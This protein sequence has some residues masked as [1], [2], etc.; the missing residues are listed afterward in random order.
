MFVVG[1]EPGKT[2]IVL[3]IKS[4]IL[5]RRW[6]DRAAPFQAGDYDLRRVG[7]PVRLVAFDEGGP[8]HALV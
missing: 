1:I 2:G 6:I 7:W 4:V 3:K 5:P 8:L